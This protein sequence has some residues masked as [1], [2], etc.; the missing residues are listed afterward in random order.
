M[1]QI[2]ILFVKKINFPLLQWNYVN[3]EMH[4]MN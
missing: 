2:D 1:E 4:Q 3:K